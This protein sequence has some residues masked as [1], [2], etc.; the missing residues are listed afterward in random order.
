M[1]ESHFPVLP[2]CAAQSASTQQP[3]VHL[4]P[5]FFIV[6][7]HVKSHFV[8]SHVAVPPVGAVHASHDPPQWAG[9]L[10]STHEPEQLCCAVGH[11]APPVPPITP[12]VPVTAPR[13]PIAPP[14]AAIALVPPLASIG[15]PTVPVPPPV[16]LD[17]N[18]P[19]TLPPRPV[20]PE[21]NPVPPDDDIPIPAFP[22]LTFVP[23]VPDVPGPPSLATVP[24]V[25]P[26]VPI[27][28]AAST[29]PPEPTAESAFAES[30]PASAASYPG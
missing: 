14:L 12:P 1:D 11:I 23:A 24:L 15:A 29:R 22:G 26:P 25:A 21:V 5:H 19:P 17:M 3:V 6:P 7:L 9:E 2:A 18:D 30:A 4:E 13:P 27:A 8:P 10:L 28:V 16:P 20:M